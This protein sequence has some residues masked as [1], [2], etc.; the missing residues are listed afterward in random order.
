MWI[1]KQKW[2]MSGGNLANNTDIVSVTLCIGY[3]INCKTKINSNFNF[4]IIMKYWYNFILFYYTVNNSK[5][6]SNNNSNLTSEEFGHD[7]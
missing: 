6:E 2:F 1:W 5:K 3:N 4:T 7:S